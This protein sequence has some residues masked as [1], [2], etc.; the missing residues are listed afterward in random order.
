MKPTGGGPADRLVAGAYGASPSRG[1]PRSGSR[2]R[3][4]AEAFLETVE[5]T[6]VDFLADDAERDA[7]IRNRFGPQVAELVRRDRQQNVRRAFRSYPLHELPESTRTINPFSLYETYLA[8]GRVVLL[9]FTILGGIARVLGLAVRSVYRVVEEILHPRLDQD[10]T[11]PSDTYL[12]ALRKIHRMRK[13]VFMGSLWLRARFDVEYLGLSLPTAPPV[14]AAESMMEVNLDYIGATRQ[15]RIIAEQVRHEHQ[16][17]LEWVGRWLKRFG[18]SFD[19]LPGFLSREIP[20]LA[21]RGGEALRALVAACVLDHDDIAS[22]ALSIE[23]L[24]RVLAY[25]ADP[26]S[27][28]RTVPP[29]L[30]DPIVNL[31]SLWHP[32]HRIRRPVVGIFDLPCFPRYDTAQRRRIVDYLRRHRR[33]VK[34]WIRIVLG[35]GGPDPWETVRTRMREVLLRTDLWSDQILVLRAV[36]SLTMLD[37]QHNCELVWNLGGYTTAP[38]PTTD[39]DEP[40]ADSDVRPEAQGVPSIPLAE[41]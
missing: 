19:E 6:A 16:V 41:A 37:V 36:Q 38:E 32:V 7:E 2:R 35:Q 27:D 4:E 13:P 22:L 20:Y 1:N 26:A 24:D 28:L 40:P 39:S 10:N 8:G 21:N 34:G 30:P 25:A 12:A 5:F 29:G 3:P 14:I 31:R 15:D 33:I 9:P 18:W 23:G 17:R 11:V